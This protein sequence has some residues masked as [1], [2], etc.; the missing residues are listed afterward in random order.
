[1]TNIEV[2]NRTIAVVTELPQ[3]PVLNQFRLI[4][5]ELLRAEFKGKVVFDLLISKGMN[6]R[7]VEAYFDGKTIVRSSLRVSSANDIPNEIVVRQ[8]HFF[9]K[10]SNLLGTSILSSQ[11]IQKLLHQT[12]I[13]TSSART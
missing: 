11:E 6:A 9:V 13:S 5:D 10:N 1:M 8:S 7:F 12:N 3:Q 4:A 2:I